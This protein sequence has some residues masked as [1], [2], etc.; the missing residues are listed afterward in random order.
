MAV[1]SYPVRD[2]SSRRY[3]DRHRFTD[4]FDDRQSNHEEI[5]LQLNL[6]ATRIAAS[7]HFHDE[8]DAISTAT[9]HAI[10]RIGKFNSIQRNAFCYFT[11]M[12]F[13]TFKRYAKKSKR[14]RHVSLDELRKSGSIDGGRCK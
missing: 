11:T 8:E 7:F 1:A 2:P 10:Q 4:L 9:V 13:N 12:I 5:C 6:M 3:I 14:Q